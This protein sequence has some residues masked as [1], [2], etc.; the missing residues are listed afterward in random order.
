MKGFLKFNRGI[1]KMPIPVRL[2]LMVLVGANMVIPLFFLGR[3]EARVVLGTFII[4]AML[5]V[6]LTARVGFN[7]L[8]GLGHILFPVLIYFLWTRLSQLP[9]DSVYGVW[10]RA[11]MLLNAISVIFDVVDVIRYI[12]GNRG[13]I[14]EGL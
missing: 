11:V 6:L 7:R 9:A 2:W 4:S 1:I 12:S 10:V 14:V 5:M 13:E 3:L 8:L